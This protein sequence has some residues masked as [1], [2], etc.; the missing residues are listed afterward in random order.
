M[1]ELPEVET[2]VRGVRDELQDR[3]IRRTRFC[4]CARKPI[5]IS[6]GKQQFRR[7]LKDRRISDIQ[8]LAKRI[9]LTLDDALFMVIE[10]RMTGL[11]LLT[12]PPTTDHRRIQWDLDTRPGHIESFE[13]WDRRGL[14]TI[15]LLNAGEF[16][17]LQARLGPDPLHMSTD[18]WKQQLSR[19]QRPVKNA[20]LDQ[21]LV[22]GIGNIYASEILHQARISPN[23]PAA[24]LSPGRV[25]GLAA[26]ATQILNEAIR[27][28]GSTLADGTYRNA[29]NRDGS[30]QNKHCVYQK[31]GQLCGTCQRSRILRIVQAQR[32]TFYCPRCQRR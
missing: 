31:E 27:Y 1:P 8:R 22:A 3:Q 29:L 28:E 30:Y 20:L 13:F 5:Q 10:P 16:E 14:G 17:Q 15:R 32:A 9:V 12:S 6:P 4:R 11:L 7:L 21:S 18:D 24:A 23:E 25:A 2:M 19:T 26:A